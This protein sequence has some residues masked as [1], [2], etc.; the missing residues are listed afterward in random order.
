MNLRS[1][2]IICL[3]TAGCSSDSAPSL[4]DVGEAHHGQFAVIPEGKFVAS[5]AN[6]A[7]RDA[8]RQS[9][10]V[11]PFEMQVHEVT[12]AQFSLFVSQTQYETDVER[13]IRENNPNAGSALFLM[14]ANNDSGH[15]FEAN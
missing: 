2:T 6:N 10:D 13:G 12:N 1:M 9:I 5:K 15:T 11:S 4:C 7:M 14:P 3:A 8:S